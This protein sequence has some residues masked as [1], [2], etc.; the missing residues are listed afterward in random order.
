M[1]L[2]S[3]SHK[4]RCDHLSSPTNLIF[5]SGYK[6]ISAT[7]CCQ[8]KRQLLHKVAKIIPRK[9]FKLIYA[10]VS[11]SQPTFRTSLENVKTRMQFG[12]I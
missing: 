6:V 9:S 7:P 1:F 11:P 12:T 8:Q 5:M 2:F 4:P 10:D 3:V